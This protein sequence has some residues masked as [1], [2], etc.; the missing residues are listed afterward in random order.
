MPSEPDL[1]P[2]TVGGLHLSGKGTLTAGGPISPG[3]QLSGVG[4]LTAGGIR[5]AVQEIHDS[6]VEELKRLLTEF[7]AAQSAGNTADA[8]D[9]AAKVET[10]TRMVSVARLLRAGTK[11]GIV[12]ILA[13]LIGL[14]FEHEA[15][16]LMGWTP[17][18]ITIVQ[19][20]SHAQMDELSHQ[21]LQ[22]IE[23]LRQ[24]QDH[25]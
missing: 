6:S 17:P 3:A 5:A 1:R 23:H 7:I 12:T 22:Q 9:L 18:S 2:V 10:T 11:W 15:N 8:G 16:D 21:I 4:T 19:Q 25:P 13:S 20:M 14:G 24:P